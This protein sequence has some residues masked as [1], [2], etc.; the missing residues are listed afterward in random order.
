VIASSVESQRGS[1]GVDELAQRPQQQR[2]VEHVG[3]VV[4]HECAAAGMPA[5]LHDLVVEAVADHQPRVRVVVP[6]AARLPDPLVGL[7]P[8]VDQPL[9]VRVSSIQPSW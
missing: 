6:P 7:I 9:Q 8:V 4:L 3:V 1:V 2:G 5:A